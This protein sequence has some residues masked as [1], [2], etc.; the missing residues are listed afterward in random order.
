MKNAFFLVAFTFLLPMPTISQTIH[1]NEIKRFVGCARTDRKVEREKVLSASFEKWFV[2]PDLDSPNPPGFWPNGCMCAQIPITL[3]A[4]RFILF[5]PDG[6]RAILVLPHMEAF[7]RIPS[8]VSFWNVR[9]DSLVFSKFQDTVWA[10]SMGYRSFGER[11]SMTDGSLLVLLTSGG[12]DAGDVWGAYAL[13][14][15]FSDGNIAFSKKEITYNWEADDTIHTEIACGLKTIQGNPK[16]QVIR[17]TYRIESIL[18]P[19]VMVAHDTSYAA[20]D[21][22]F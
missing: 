7:E 6:K 4:D 8:L 22:M 2:L 14:Q 15:W 12:G 9:S 3:S 17:K 20:I 13:M 1:K 16:L 10:T 18:K 21:E 5:S 11:V 19:P